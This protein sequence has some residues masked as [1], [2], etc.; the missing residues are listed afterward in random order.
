[1]KS[2]KSF[3]VGSALALSACSGGIGSKQDAA[4]ALSRLM[5]ASSVASSQSQSQASALQKLTINGTVTVSGRSGT[6]TV[7]MKASG[8]SGDPSAALDIAFSGFSADGKNTFDGTQ[9]Y[10][11]ATALSGLS[12]AVTTSMNADVTMS[13]EYDAKMTC[14]VTIAMNAALTSTSGKFSMTINGTVTADGKTYTFENESFEVDVQ[15]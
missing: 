14:D 13:G 9:E 4:Q 11:V 8:G 7:T 2:L 3:A 10:S 6:A 12:A 1:M 15:S 5:V